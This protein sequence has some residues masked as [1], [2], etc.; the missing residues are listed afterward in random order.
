MTDKGEL[1]NLTDNRPHQGVVLRTN[2]LKTTDITSLPEVS[3][4]SGNGTA[5]LWIALDE[6]QDPQNL[7]SIIRLRRTAYFFA[8][9]GIVVCTK[10]SAPL[11]G[12]VSRVSAGALECMDI[13]SASQ[14]PKLLKNSKANGWQVIGAAGRDAKDASEGNHQSLSS[15]HTSESL[16]NVNQPRILVLGNEGTGLRRNVQAVCDSFLG[17]DRLQQDD[18]PGSVDSLNVGVA[19]G[20]LISHLKTK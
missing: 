1:N 4:K 6:I 5:P 9:D 7:G 15:L 16:I 17:I 18:R 3:D 19:T 14:L 13:Y 8:V 2:P 20:I 12:V 11:S 10:N